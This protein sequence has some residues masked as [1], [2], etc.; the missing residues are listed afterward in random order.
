[1]N[2]RSFIQTGSA[3]GLGIG[4]AGCSNSP[5]AAQAQTQP[6]ASSGVHPA[7]AALK[8][9]TGDVKPITKEERAAAAERQC[10]MKLVP[11]RGIAS[12]MA[13]PLG[14]HC[15]LVRRRARRSRAA[16]SPYSRIPCVAGPHDSAVPEFSRRSW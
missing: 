9:M 11:F 15:S 8:P 1:M 3:A 5:E 14:D 10:G 13:W 12:S 4:I 16:L 2:R 7:L 6:V